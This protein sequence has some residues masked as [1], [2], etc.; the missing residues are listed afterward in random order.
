MYDNYF[1]TLDYKKNPLI[2]FEGRVTDAWPDGDSLITWAPC[3]SVLADD[4]KVDY[5][6][7]RVN[8]NHYSN[9]LFGNDKE[10]YNK[11]QV[12]LD[13]YL[14]AI[15]ISKVDLRKAS[16]EKSIPIEFMEHFLHYKNVA[17]YHIINSY[18]KPGNYEFLVKEFRLLDGIL[19]NY[20]NVD[21][22]KLTGKYSK[23]KGRELV[24]EY[25]M[26]KA[27]TGRLTTKK[28]SFPI[29]NLDKKFRETIIPTNSVFVEMDYNS[30]EVRVLNWY[31]GKSDDVSLDI[32]E[33]NS[34]HV[35]GGIDRESAKKRFFAWLYNP[36]KEDVH[37]DSV[38][39]RKEITK[40]N[41]DGYKLK[42]FYGRQI[43]TDEYHALNYLI[44]STASDMAI[45]SAIKM[46]EFLKRRGNMSSISFM[47]HDSIVV[48]LAVEDL[49]VIRDL[50][51][52]AENTDLGRI[53]VSVKVGD[54][55]GNMRAR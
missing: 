34:T 23:F 41:Y 19:F 43:E 37:L 16:L 48:D 8:G 5:A 52:I 15:T 29:L 30:A 9:Y 26:F 21:A 20:L 32:H 4:S 47:V 49:E 6:I 28:D 27:V 12:K 38:Y 22:S 51:S 14:K 33:W 17:C 40:Q 44:Q 13:A 50:I 2:F 36:A 45:S 7:F 35:F 54:N 53:P 1:Q 18:P 10:N 25:D 11:L 24:V 46:S 3:R 31:A 55:Y 39:N 42:N